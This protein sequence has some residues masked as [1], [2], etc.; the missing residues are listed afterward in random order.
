MK[1]EYLNAKVKKSSLSSEF[2]I[3]NGKNLRNYACI[4]SMYF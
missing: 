2:Y 3:V 4:V 1:K